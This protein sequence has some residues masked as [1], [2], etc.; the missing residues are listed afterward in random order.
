LSNQFRFGPFAS[1]IWHSNAPIT[2]ARRVF[3]LEYAADAGVTI[4]NNDTSQTQFQVCQGHQVPD[5]IG[6]KQLRRPRSTLAM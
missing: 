3:T 1:P 2:Q 5:E 4:R 6:A